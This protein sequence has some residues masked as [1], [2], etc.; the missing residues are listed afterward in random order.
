MSLIFWPTVYDVWALQRQFHR[1][2]HQKTDC[3]AL[4]SMKIL[5]GLT[6]EPQPSDG[7]LQQLSGTAIEE[8]LAAVL[9]H[10][11]ASQSLWDELPQQR[12]CHTDR[13]TDREWHRQTKRHTHSTSVP[14]TQVICCQVLTDYLT[15]YS[16]KAQ[17][18]TFSSE[19]TDACWLA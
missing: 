2:R 18:H 19:T 10:P 4:T 7:V 16:L 9:T 12:F 15:A 5:F 11:L 3:E 14:A 13:Q 6:R 8:W 17:V 1:D